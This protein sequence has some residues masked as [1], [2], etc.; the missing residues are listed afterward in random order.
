MI[1][2]QNENALKDAVDAKTEGVSSRQVGDKKHAHLTI[3][4]LHN[5]GMIH[6]H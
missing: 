4:Q 2:N 1:P 3:V 6:F 5:E